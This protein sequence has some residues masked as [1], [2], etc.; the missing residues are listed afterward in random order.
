[1]KVQALTFFPQQGVE[2]IALRLPKDIMALNKLNQL[3][4]SPI[5]W[6]KNR[7]GNPGPVG[8]FQ[9]ASEIYLTDGTIQSRFTLGT[10]G[11]SQK[12]H[13]KPVPK[14]TQAVV[15]LSPLTNPNPIKQPRESQ[16]INS[17]SS[18]MGVMDAESVVVQY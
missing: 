15:K 6:R 18:S 16:R 12:L 14:I 9:D 2:K 17:K 10:L 11:N 13:E 1:M 5:A 4:L 3:D 7:V 8:S